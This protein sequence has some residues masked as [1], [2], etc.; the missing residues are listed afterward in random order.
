M[1]IAVT[2]PQLG[3]AAGPDAI[4]AAAIQAEELG[5]SHVWVN[6][7]ITFPVGQSHPSKYM[8]DPLLTPATAAAVTTEIRL[9]GQV[10]AAYYAPLWLA[11]ALASLDSLSGG[12]LNV[13]IGVGWSAGMQSAPSTRPMR[14]RAC[15]VSWWR[16]TSAKCTRGCD[17]S[18]SSQPR[19]SSLLVD[20]SARSAR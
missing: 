10:T 12:R 18:R 1:D 11:N 2:L 15:N 3:H 9:G 8:Y 16:P 5:F 20:K 14:R 17:R 6:D 13:A 4:R 7:H 19:S